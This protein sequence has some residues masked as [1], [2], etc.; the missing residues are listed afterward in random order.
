MLLNQIEL[1]ITVAKHHHLGK[2][3]EEIHVSASSVCQR[4]KSLE[5]GLGVKLYKKKREGIEL[6]GA[7]ETLLTTASDFLN[8]LDRLKKTLNSSDSQPVNSDS[9][10]AV[11]SLTVGGTYNPS[12]KYL[13]E[14]IAAFQKKHPD[15]K[16]TFLTSERTNIE[17]LLRKSEVEIAIIQSPTK[18]ADFNLEHFGADNLTFFAHPKHPLFQKKKLDLDDLSRTPLIVRDVR[19]PSHKMLKQLERPGLMFNLALQ[20][21][22]PEAVKAAVRTKMGVG[23][24]FCNHIQEDVKRK[25]FKILKFSGLPKIVGNSYIVHSKSKPLSS[26]AEEFLTLLR[27]RKTR[28]KNPASISENNED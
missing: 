6:T 27:S 26:A 10:P 24:L 15:I 19:G 20:C 22:S 17:K 28:I 8:Q 1:F 25:H 13:P 21:K 3:A 12:A 4:L 23:V 5:N 18:S 16:V 2:T 9:Q 14:A 7:G 11:Q